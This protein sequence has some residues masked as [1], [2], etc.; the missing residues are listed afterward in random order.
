MYYLTRLG[1]CRRSPVK[2]SLGGEKLRLSFSWVAWSLVWCLTCEHVTAVVVV[3]LE[4][5][6]TGGLCPAD[7][8]GGGAGQHSV[9]RQL[10]LHLGPAG[11]HQLLLL[12][13]SL[14]LTAALRQ[15]W[16]VISDSRT[17]VSKSIYLSPFFV[18]HCLSCLLNQRSLQL[19]YFKI[20][21]CWM[22]LEP[23]LFYCLICPP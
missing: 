9:Q 23:V 17:D 2:L 14:V 16:S 3:V 1:L 7:V 22:P 8:G 11:L 6:V 15:R 13:A 19:K 4:G 18:R 21:L 10:L 5:G 20:F 12:P